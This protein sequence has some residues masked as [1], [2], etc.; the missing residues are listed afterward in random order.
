MM[1]S[2]VFAPVSVF[3]LSTSVFAG[4]V[5]Q[6]ISIDFDNAASGQVVAVGTMSGDYD[7]ANGADFVGQLGLWNS[8]P[9]GTQDFDLA[10]R[11]SDERSTGPLTT[12]DGQQVA[13]EFRLN[14]GSAA[15]FTTGGLGFDPLTGDCLALDAF[16]YFQPATSDQLSWSIDHL[17]PGAAYDI[18][19]YSPFPGYDVFSVAGG[20]LYTADADNNTLLAGVVAD[21]NGRIVGEFTQPLTPIPVP[22]WGGLQIRGEFPAVPEPAASLMLALAA[23]I[24]R[25]RRR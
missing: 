4:T 3:L 25:R 16:G 19:M 21:A 11:I 6:L 1:R 23:A 20:S 7:S 22:Y 10:G 8:L 2:F 24:G 13:T 17:I 14:L 12:G 9:L 15:E 5:D 18:K